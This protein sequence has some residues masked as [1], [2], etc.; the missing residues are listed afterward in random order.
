MQPPSSRM[1]A[2]PITKSTFSLGNHEFTFAVIYAILEAL[3]E[4]RIAFNSDKK[5]RWGKKNG[6]ALISDKNWERT[7]TGSGKLTGIG[8][9]IS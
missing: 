4:I 2:L 7:T 3:G 6:T 5:N 8:I 9:G 1:S